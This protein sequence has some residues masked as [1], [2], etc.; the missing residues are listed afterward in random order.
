MKSWFKSLGFSC[1]HWGK[2]LLFALWSVWLRLE[3]RAVKNERGTPKPSP[4]QGWQRLWFEGF[5]HEKQNYKHSMHLEK[6]KY[7]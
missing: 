3:Q 2:R 5:A 4:H 1:P 7:L 6:E